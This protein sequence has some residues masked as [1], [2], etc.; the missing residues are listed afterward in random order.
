MPP[1]VAHSC[2]RIVGPRREVIK[3][4]SF[5]VIPVI[6]LKGGVAVHAVGGRRDQ[7]RPLRSV[8]QAS[9]PPDELA[10]AIRKGLGVAGLYVADLDAIEGGPAR[11]DLYRRLIATGLELHLD[12]GVRDLLSLDPLVGLTAHGVRIV[13]GLES[14]R[15]PRVLAA[16]IERIGPECAVL[17]L[18]LDDRKPRLAAGADWPSGDPLEIAAEAVGLGVRHLILLDLLRVGTD[19][20]TGTESLLTS[21]R[22]R[23]PGVD[24]TVGG[25]VRG[26]EDILR[27]RELG[28]SAVLVGSAIHD[29]RI[30]RTGVEQ[31]ENRPG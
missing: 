4:V 20:G 12:A 23:C 5:R 15:G 10:A 8:W 6:D 24:V 17:S 14:V 19:R 26:I 30:G 13:V 3:A 28:A 9:G 21:L 22:G 25:G 1:P 11:V 31:I 7:Y 29:G 18:D 2:T 16:I 27:M